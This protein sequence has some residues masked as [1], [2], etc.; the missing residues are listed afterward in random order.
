MLANFGTHQKLKQVMDPLY[1][2]FKIKNLRENQE[3]LEPQRIFARK[4]SGVYK[5]KS[6]QLLSPEASFLTLDIL[7]DV[8]RLGLNYNITNNGLKLPVYWKTGTSS[9]LKDAWSVGV[10][11]K[12]VLVIWV[13]DFKGKSK[14]AFIGIKTASPL[15]FSIIDTILMHGENKDLIMNRAQDLNLTKVLVCTD[16]GDINNN[17]CPNKIYCWFIPGKSPIKSTDIYQEII[18]NKKTGKQVCKFIEGE[19]KYKIISLWPSDLLKLY[20]RA[21]IHKHN[22]SDILTK[23]N[24]ITSSSGKLEIVS[25]LKSVNYSIKRDNKITFSAI[26]HSSAKEIFWFI[27]NKLVG[28]SAPSELFVWEAQTGKI[29][30]HAVDD[31][32]NSDSRKLIIEN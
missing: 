28:K 26:A 31:N 29:V 3:A 4:Y 22:Y 21:G 6:K 23:C 10:F 7:K 32:G 20:I 24:N 12:Y 27:G 11:G 9:S 30:V 15:F 18:I 14:G 8:A 16:T 19:S 1:S 2:P 13:G 17:F 5:E 25:P